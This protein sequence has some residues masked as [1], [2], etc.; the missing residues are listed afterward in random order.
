MNK[1]AVYNVRGEKVKEIELNPEVFGLA[2]NPRLVAQAIVTQQANSRHNFASVKDR[3]DVSGGGRKPWRQKGTGRAR[4]GSIRSPLWRG[5]G[6][7]FGPSKNQ[8]YSLKINRKARQK[9]ILMSLSDKASNEKIIFIDNLDLAEAKT[10][11]FFEI[12]QNL[13]LRPEIKKTKKTVGS[14]QDKQEIKKIIK[15]EE[16]KKKLE[17]KPKEKIKSV[18]VVLPKKDEKV[19]RAGNNI[20]RLVTILADSL[21]VVDVVKSQYILMPVDAVAEI[22]KTFSS[23]LA[24]AKSKADSK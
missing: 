16:A 4:H 18:L 23:G 5:G 9:A 21:N 12:L 3:S 15:K 14:V 20:P 10:K 19:K 7:T 2:V 24:K 8:N 13:K 6:V 22:K 17:K 11:K 1:V